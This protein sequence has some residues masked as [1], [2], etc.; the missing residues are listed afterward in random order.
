MAS[1]L[2]TGL[3]TLVLVHDVS[4]VEGIA[5]Q[6]EH[7]C[8]GFDLM[9]SSNDD[10]YQHL[11]NGEKPCLIISGYDKG[12]QAV[13]SFLKQARRKHPKVPFVVLASRIESENAIELFRE[14]V[15]DIVLAHD[16]S[17]LANL[18][19]QNEGELRREAE[20]LQLVVDVINGGFWDWD[21]TTGKVYYSKRWIDAFGYTEETVE[22]T[23]AFW[24]GTVHPDDMPEVQEKLKAHA[25][26]KTER[27]EHEYRM[28][29]GD[30]TYV[31]NRDTA[32]IV[33]RDLA[34]KPLRAIGCNTDISEQKMAESRLARAKK[35]IDKAEGNFQKI[36]DN[37]S[38]GVAI[39]TFEGQILLM[40]EFALKMTGYSS[41]N[42]IDV[43]GRSPY[44]H[45]ED[46]TAIIEQLK[47]TGS[48]DGKEV[49]MLRKSG[50]QIWVNLSARVLK[51]EG[52]DA[53]LSTL[54]DIS[55]TKQAQESLAASEEQF[56]SFF[57]QSTVP[58][59]IFNTEG[60]MVEVNHAWQEMWEVWDVNEVVGKYN[61]RKDPQLVDLGLAQELEAA[62]FG[63]DVALSDFV[64]DPSI[65]GYPG[66]LRHLRVKAFP[67]KN[68]QKITSVVVFNED[69]TSEIETQTYLKQSERRLREAQAVAQIGSFEGD[70]YR[71]ELWWSDELYNLFGLDPGTFK[72]TKDS[73][74]S[75]L[76]PADKDAYMTALNY[77]LEVGGQFK[78]EFRG[79]H[80]SGKWR[81]FETIAQVTYDAKGEILGLQGTVQDIT[82]RKHSNEQL[83]LLTE[84]LH[85]AVDIA[86]LGYLEMRPQENETHWDRRLT[87]IFEWPGDAPGSSDEKLEHFYKIIHAEDKEAIKQGFEQSMDPANTETKF[88][89]EFRLR[90]SDGRVKHVEFNAVH[91]RNDE[92]VV[93]Q[94]NGTCLDVTYRKKADEK[95]KQSAQRFERW[96]SSNFVGILQS[97]GNGEIVDAN[98]TIL[99]LLGYTRQEL[100]EGKLDWKKLTPTEFEDLDTK[101]AVEAYQLGYWT[102]YEKEY[103]H[104]SGRR[105]PI[106]LGGAAYDKKFDEYIAFVVD[107]TE[108][109]KAERKIKNSEERLKILFESA[110][111]AYYIRD[112][113]GRFIDCNKATQQLLG[114]TR[115]EMIGHSFFEMGI[116]AAQDAEKAKNAIEERLTKQNFDPVE[117]DM[118]RKDGKH[119]PVEALAHPV[120]MNGKKVVLGIVRDISSR[121][122][123]ERE[124]TKMGTAMQQ[125]PAMVFITDLKG[126]LEY[127][128]PKFEETTGYTAAEVLGKNPRFLKSGH[129]SDEEYRN[130]WTTITSGGIWTGEF[131]NKRKDG[132]LYWERASIGP[133]FDEKN[134]ITHYVAVKEDTTQL[135]KAEQNLINTLN[136]TTEQNKR[137]QN[138][139]Y[140]VSHNLRSHSS[141]ISGILNLMDSAGTDEEKM[142]LQGMLKTVSAKLDE[143]MYHLTDAVSTLIEKD[144]FKEALVLRDYLDSALG[145]LSDELFQRSVLVQNVV[146]ATTTVCCNAAYLDSI[147]LNILS[148]A[149]KYASPGRQARIEIRSKQVHNEVELQ[150]ADNGL[151]IDLKRHGESLF[152]MYKTFHTNKDARGIGLFI[153]KNQLESV[154]GRIR[155][156]ST[157]GEG[158]TFILTFKDGESCS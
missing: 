140:I 137:L 56:R 95:L 101:A 88:K 12:Q 146:D 108:S 148:N 16:L 107:L 59:L 41:E 142:K 150:I 123:V 155:A 130:L 22:P 116:I 93:T 114:Y 45:Q 69:V 138:F 14:G 53:V 151:G 57:E 58:S 10:D 131:K 118:V 104:K 94:I 81:H 103:F 65:S 13:L 99:D 78:R 106:L 86:E 129:T 49:Q 36:F 8:P 115:E 64:F 44:V 37:A 139:S 136:L 82:T 119:V 67:I 122:D 6:L 4:D 35:K 117:Y 23:I 5:V 15:T 133:V 147:L 47:Q 149:I 91:Q 46:R 51:W 29:R 132:S 24:E 127:V 110:P 79:K 144:P 34:G 124:L 92:G 100:K 84:R 62:F 43:K 61:I 125:S 76:H 17:A 70:V 111:D 158:S 11:M 27:F 145:I 32:K 75:L 28:L 135:K 71:D 134:R 112:M 1:S 30:G 21:M 26:G 152:G 105:I 96:K 157:V 120:V 38:I 25:E 83:A 18:S 39:S 89:S 50:E 154:G 74:E 121:K 31:W 77:S 33:E 2:L 80:T 126:N 153:C 42:L 63:K 68:N 3:K 128:N 97:N 52:Q 9:V 85:L 54:L 102:P 20:Q 87:E 98:D 113:E 40:N 55:E 72:V 90:F 60:Y 19:L 109:K 143:T 48:V 66:R 73:F 156:E 7:S 141:N